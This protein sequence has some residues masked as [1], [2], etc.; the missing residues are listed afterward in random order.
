[1]YREFIT[2]DTVE[3]LIVSPIGSSCYVPLQV[4]KE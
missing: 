3:G 1:M 4:A 2:C